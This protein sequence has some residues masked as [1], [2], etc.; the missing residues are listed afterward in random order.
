MSATLGRSPAGSSPTKTPPTGS[1]PPGAGRDAASGGGVEQH[2]YD[3]IPESDRYMTPRQL[4]LFW[5]GINAYQFFFV[6]GSI[7]VG[8][9]LS[10]V[11]AIIAIACGNLLFGVVAYCSVA[12]PRAGMPT[13][14]FSRAAFGVLGNRVNAVCTWAMSL[15]FKTVNGLLGVFAMLALF[16][17]LG[18]HDS[19]GALGKVVATVVVLGGSIV[20]AVY[21]HRALVRVQPYF[22][23]AV[24]LI[25]LLI[26]GNIVGDVDWGWKPDDPATGW[27]GVALVLI[28]CALISSGPLSY[29][30]V[31]P[32]YARYL[33][34]GTPTRK[35]FRAVFAGGA[36]MVMFL[37]TVGAV[38]ATRADLSDP[39]AGMEPLL[40]GWLFV[41]YIVASFTGAV[42]NNASV[43]YSSG[44]AIQAIGIPARRWVATAVDAMLALAAVLWVLFIYDFEH[45]LNEF[46]A[47]VVVWAGPFCAVWITDGVMRR[48]TYDRESVHISTPASRYWGTAGVNV[49]GIVSMLAGMA[50]ALLTINSAL[51]KGWLSTRMDGADL[52][53]FLPLIVSA[54]AYAVLGRRWVR[55]TSLPAAA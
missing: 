37:G 34:S 50:T 21:G 45:A 24:T 23:A 42:G 28:A 36:G 4:G 31:A 51:V 35:I 44:L 47:L 26:V 38:A 20:I 3:Y 40:P 29:M 6:L 18:W 16:D 19:G 8:M 2:G 22:A 39:V 53:W 10:L 13:T 17:Q 11:Q 52:S 33:P 12:G 14:A 49:A 55:E 5:M 25:F 1:P 54:A 32:D 30:V 41:L 43:F 7:A 46:L 27:G 48:W 9:G 15:G